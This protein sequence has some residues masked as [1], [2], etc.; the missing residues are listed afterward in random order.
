LIIDF[1]DID[2]DADGDDDVRYVILPSMLMERR[3]GMLE[4]QL[5]D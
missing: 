4:K 2:F 1:D 3:Q 5:T